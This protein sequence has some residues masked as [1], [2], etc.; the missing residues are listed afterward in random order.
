MVV[1]PYQ[2]VVPLLCAFVIAYA[3][4]LVYRQKKTIWEGLLWT[5]FWGVVAFAA[6]LPGQMRFL[7]E[8]TGI[9]RNENAIIVTAIGVQFF[10][11]FYLIIRLEELEHRMTKILREE[12]LEETDIP[13]KTSTPT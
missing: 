1:T 3:W 10:M 11:M 5:L 6:V 2:I 13:T 9:Q 12:A 4:H 7:S 8:I